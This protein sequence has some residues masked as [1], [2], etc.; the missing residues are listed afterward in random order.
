MFGCLY[1]RNKLMIIK[2]CRVPVGY[3]DKVSDNYGC[4]L[5]FLEISRN[6]RKFILIFQ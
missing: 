2:E 3:F 4:E 6:F 1:W 5:G